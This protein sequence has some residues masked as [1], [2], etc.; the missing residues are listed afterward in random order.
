[1]PQVKWLTM[2]QTEG[3]KCI[4]DHFDEFR[5]FLIDDKSLF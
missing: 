1:M 3:I 2:E 4:Y 5:N